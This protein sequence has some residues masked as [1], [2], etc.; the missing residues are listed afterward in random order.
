MSKCVV[1]KGDG[2]IYDRMVDYVCSKCENPT[3]EQSLQMKINRLEMIIKNNQEDRQ[4]S[5]GNQRAFFD[6]MDNLKKE[7]AELKAWKEENGGV[8]KELR[9]CVEFYSDEKNWSG[10]IFEGGGENSRT[11]DYEIINAIIVAGKRAR[12][13]LKKVDAY[14]NRELHKED[15]E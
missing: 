13:C 14:F 10:I 8:V 5:L 7:L 9:E 2:F 4:A 11:P 15:N 3:A 6:K 1:C 12:Q